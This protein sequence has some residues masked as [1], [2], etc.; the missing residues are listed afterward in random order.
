M[1][2]L[3]SFN[4]WMFGYGSPTTMGL[5]RAVFCAIVFVNLAMVAVD[6]N[7]WFTE[8]GYVPTAILNRWSGGVFRFS[9]LQHVTNSNVTA[10]FYGLTM[11]AALMTTLGLYTRVASI[12]LLIGVTSLHHRCPD[13][14]HSGDTLVRAM[15][16]YIAVAP[17][18]AALSLDRWIAVRRG[19][20]PAEPL[21]VSLWPQRMMQIQ[22]A[23]V[24]LTTVWHKSFGNWW[25]NG[26]ATWYPPQ[27]D[28]FD[29]FPVPHFFDQQPMVAVMTYGTL[30][31]ELALGTLVFAKPL[32]KWVLLAGVLLH[33]GI[34]WRMNIPLFSFITVATYMVFYEGRETAEW[35]KRLVEKYKPLRTISHRW[36][37][38]RK[39]VATDP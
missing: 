10:V 1:K 39:E 26:T 25:L 11:L 28:E 29:R 24:Y 13:I 18:G 33:A 5:F 30:V 27:L 15:L 22:I 9:L 7:A 35:L 2:A 38:A 16:L 31:A 23:I 34:E 37:P 8:T 21:D 36:A 3:R 14:L 12:A 19:T 20:A 4:E 6:F 17:S 32:R